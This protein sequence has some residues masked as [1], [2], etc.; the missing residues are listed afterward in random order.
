MRSYRIMEALSAVD[1]ELL[2]RCEQDYRRRRKT[3][4]SAGGVRGSRFIWRRA[5]SLA[6]VLCLALV[7]GASLVGYQFLQRTENDGAASGGEAPD[8]QMRQEIYSM[9]DAEE[10][11]TSEEWGEPESDVNGNNMDDAGITQNPEYDGAD[12]ENVT[13]GAASPMEGEVGNDKVMDREDQLSE[14]E[15]VRYLTW[16]EAQELE[17]LGGYFPGQ[18]PEG[19]T[20]VEAAYYPNA[21]ESL[22]VVWGR[23]SDRIVLGIREMG[24]TAISTVDVGAPETYDL[25][26]Y[27]EPYEETVPMEYRES[28]QDPVFAFGDFGLEVVRSRM[29]SRG[30]AG[31]TDM[32][33]GRFGVLYPDGVLVSFDGCGTAEEIWEMFCSIGEGVQ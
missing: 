18:L 32:S 33:A 22:T 21:L 15:E 11:G 24:G 17:G 30:E 28:F 13:E 1:E 8:E 25:R 2:V 9:A 16:E 4:S 7:G 20:F 27:E 3:Q 29:V 10:I 31:E 26:I 5:G 6:A 19:Y 12:M 23:G 14:R